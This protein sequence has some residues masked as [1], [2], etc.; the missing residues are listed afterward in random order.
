MPHSRSSN[1]SFLPVL[2]VLVALA[3]RGDGPEAPTANTAEFLDAG[4]VAVLVG[5]G[6]ATG[7]YKTGKPYAT[8]TATAKLLDS[9]GGTVFTLGDN[10]YP[11][12]TRSD[13]ANCYGPTWGKHKARTRPALGNHEY[14]ISPDPY[15]DYF[16]GPGRESGRAGRRGKGYYSYELV[17]WH[18]VVLNSEIDKSARSP[19]ASWLRADLAA[20]P[21]RCILAYWHRP[22][23][24]SGPHAPLERITPLVRIL[25]TAGVDVILSGH[26]HQYERFAPQ[27]V[28]RRPDP[29]G[30]RAFVVGTGG[31]TQYGFRSPQPNSMVRYSGSPGV[32]KLTLAETSYTWQF[33]LTSGRVLDKGTGRCHLGPG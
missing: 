15:F 6:D 33:V 13:F 16:N 3:C 30:I 25:D 21:A 17:G 5:A 14:V 10:A 8:S 4:R 7:C 1:L 2:M 24:T 11:Y 22:F 9:L 20:H 29:A 27:D 19:Q 26:N 31:S 18:I 32:L 23:F 28:E 12:G